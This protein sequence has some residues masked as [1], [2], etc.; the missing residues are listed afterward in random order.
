MVRECFR[1]ETGLIFD[2]DML[3]DEL[4]MDID[5]DNRRVLEAPDRAEPGPLDFVQNQ[6]TEEA[7]AHILV[8][9]AKDTGKFVIY[10]LQLAWW[11]IGSPFRNWF[12]HTKNMAQGRRRDLSPRTPFLG[13]AQEELKDSLSPMY[14]QLQLSRPW[15]I[16]ELLPLKRKK[17]RAIYSLTDR[18]A[19]YVWVYV[20]VFSPFTSSRLTTFLDYRMNW[21]RGRKVFKHIVHRGMKIHRSVLTRLEAL[22]HKG[23]DGT[24]HPAVRPNVVIKKQ[25]GGDFRWCE[26]VPNKSW[27]QGL[28]E[29][30]ERAWF[31]WVR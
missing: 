5:F 4:G 28:I 30:L 16:L 29:G 7:V 9:A 22:D 21:G 13:E 23:E 12:V 20:S 8:A 31:E 6:S 18:A 2:M 19:D 11:L 15:W 24:Y 17:Q 26:R 14:D 27:R 25:D 1:V 10:P 3:R